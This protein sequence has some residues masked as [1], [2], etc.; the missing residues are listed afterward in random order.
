[1]CCLGQ[2]VEL[3]FCPGACRRFHPEGDAGAVLA[4]EGQEYATIE[5]DRGAL[6]NEVKICGRELPHGGWTVTPSWFDLKGAGHVPETSQAVEFENAPELPSRVLQCF[7]EIALAG[8]SQGQ[9]AQLRDVLLL[10]E[11]VTQCV[12][13]GSEE[14]DVLQVRFWD[15]VV[16]FERPG[17]ITDKVERQVVSVQC[18]LQ[19][20]A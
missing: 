7:T 11:L 20:I 2:Q 12:E 15:P 5:L 3:I 18:A 16:E 17:M 8:E 6:S 10:V 9:G 1:M 19:L 4:R 14:S 13:A